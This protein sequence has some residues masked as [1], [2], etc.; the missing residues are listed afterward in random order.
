MIDG[1]I[2]LTD[3]SAR[4]C[5]T[6]SDDHNTTAKWIIKRLFISILSYTKLLVHA[7]VEHSVLRDH[8]T[9]VCEAFLNANIEQQL[10][11]II[12]TTILFSTCTEHTFVKNLV[13]SPQSQNIFD[14]P[15]RLSSSKELKA[16]EGSGQLA[17]C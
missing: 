6:T 2:T 13:Q 15:S 7:L 5:E 10:T 3:E 8:N 9:V 14:T 16:M 11:C 17:I 12:V 4:S 1:D